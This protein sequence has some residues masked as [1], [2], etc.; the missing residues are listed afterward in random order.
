M[1]PV[2]KRRAKDNKYLQ[3]LFELLVYQNPNNDWIEDAD[4]VR[5]CA[6]RNR[7][8]EESIESAHQESFIYSLEVLATRGVLTKWTLRELM[9]ELPDED[10]EPAYLLA[11]KVDEDGRRFYRLNFPELL[12]EQREFMSLQQT[13]DNLLEEHSDY[14]ERQKTYDWPGQY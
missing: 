11:M 3:R 12:I 14:L 7:P 5:W 4:L 10:A 1:H 9:G 2:L 6:E 8:P 13:L